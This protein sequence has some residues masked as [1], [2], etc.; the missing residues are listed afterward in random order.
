MEHRAAQM[1]TQAITQDYKDNFTNYYLAGNTLKSGSVNEI[2]DEYFEDACTIQEAVRFVQQL[3][4]QGR[5]QHVVRS[6]YHQCVLAVLQ[7]AVEKYGEIFPV[8]LRGCFGNL[9]LKQHL[10][11][12]GTTDRTVA[13]FYGEVQEFK[14]VKGLKVKSL[15]KS[16]VT[17]E[18]D[19]DDEEI[20]FFP[21]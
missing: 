6:K 7:M 2:P 14:F 18:Y 9:P 19:Y 12:F 3:G 8:V 16:V 4:C 13:E 21:H 15:V 1:N 11:L 20:I 17:D 10:I 5:S